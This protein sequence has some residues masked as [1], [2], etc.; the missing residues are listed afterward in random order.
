MNFQP[1]YFTDLQWLSK[2]SFR[3]D[4]FK[5]SSA[6]SNVFNCRCPICGDSEKSTRKARFYFYTKQHSLNTICHNCGYSRSFWN[7]MSDVFPNEFP[8][9]KRDQIKARLDGLVGTSKNRSTPTP[10]PTHSQTDETHQNEAQSV[11]EGVTRI[12]KLPDTHEAV[13]YLKNR[14]FG[15]EEMSR[16]FWSDDFK[17]TAQSVSSE[18]LSNE[19]PSESRIVIPFYDSGGDIEMIQG[20]SLSNNG[21]RYISIKKH[22]EIDKIYGKYEVD[23]TKTTYCVEGPFDSLFVENCLATCDSNLM[24]A[25]ADVYIF[26]N[27]PRN[28]EIVKLMEKTIQSGKSIVIWPTSPNGKEDINDMILSGMTKS[29]LMKTIKR[30]T[31][32]GVKAKLAFMKWKKV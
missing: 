14:G 19:F 8:E 5:T 9:Y 3:F 22:P 26:D 6:T 4:K 1:D 15:Q 31:M 13:K 28:T 18:P 2:I 32:S 12:T 7:F 30:N 27:Q 16:L 25:D 17:K 11:L 10:S 24:R 29:D 23:P 20:R 21:L